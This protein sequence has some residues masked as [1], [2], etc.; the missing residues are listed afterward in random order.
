MK[1]FIYCFFLTISSVVSFAQ[2]FEYEYFLPTEG[3]SGVV[4]RWVIIEGSTCDGM[5][6]EHSPDS[7]NYSRIHEV[8]GT[9]G[10]ANFDVPYQF[11]HTDPKENSKNYYR[12]RFGQIETSEAQCIFILDN[13]TVVVPNPVSDNLSIY[14][15]NPF[16]KPMHI[17]IYNGNGQMIKTGSTIGNK[18]SSNISSLPKGV[19]FY[20]LFNGIDLRGRFIKQ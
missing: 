18:Y 19:Y 17:E 1:A 16:S 6:V 20:R 10:S 12:I 13:S 7:I 4:I 8:F 11:T 2:G 5:I 14:F 9:C 3:D 15:E